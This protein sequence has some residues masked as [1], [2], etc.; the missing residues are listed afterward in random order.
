MGIFNTVT[1]ELNIS[2][3]YIPSIEFNNTIEYDLN[4]RRD[5]IKQLHSKIDVPDKY[6]G[7]E[8]KC[9]GAKI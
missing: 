3:E 4:K 7:F 6:G 1:H 8:V 9:L 5:Y 2:R